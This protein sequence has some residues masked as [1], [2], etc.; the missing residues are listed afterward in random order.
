MIYV[1]APHFRKEEMTAPIAEEIAKQAGVNF[2]TEPVDSGVFVLEIGG[3]EDKLIGDTIPDILIDD[4]THTKIL[5]YALARNFNVYNA[6]F[7]TAMSKMF[8]SR[9]V[10]LELT[11]KVRFNPEYRELLIKTVVEVIKEIKKLL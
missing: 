8:D 10:R 1:C 11:N 9:Y 2:S 6:T 3:I 4:K 5:T 7:S